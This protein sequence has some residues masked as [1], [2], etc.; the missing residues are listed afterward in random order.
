MMNRVILLGVPLDSVTQEEAVARLLSYLS[1]PGQAH[2]AT[3]NPEMLVMASVDQAFHGLLNRTDLNL[4]D[5]A[6][7]LRL[8]AATGQ[9][10]PERVTGVDTVTALCRQLD[11]TQPIFLLGSLPGVADKAAD[12][13]MALNPN[14]RIAGTFAGSPAEAD[15][16]DIIQR[17]NASGAQLLLVAYGAPKQDFW[18]DR[19]LKEMPQ[20]KLAMGV[21]GTFDFLAGTVKRAPRFFR[22]HN[23]EWLWR[24]ITQPSRLPRIW[25]ATVVFP[26][27]VKQYGKNTRNS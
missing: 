20:V 6:G 25:K 27:L 12:T 16:S 15:A 11:G 14:L 18:I 26:R 13:L 4:P 7:L 1:A 21:G 2:V 24:L 10:L 3:P 23:L 5:G 19:Y 9:H 8:A 17:I 22:D